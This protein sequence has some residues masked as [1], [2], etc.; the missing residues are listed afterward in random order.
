MLAGIAL[1]VVGFVVWKRRS[2]K[3]GM[4][5]KGEN[6]GWAGYVKGLRKKKAG[7]D[8]GGVVAKEMSEDSEDEERKRSRDGAGQR[9]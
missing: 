4:V 7:E 8:D 9:V 2:G 3:K 5:V 6:K 1:L